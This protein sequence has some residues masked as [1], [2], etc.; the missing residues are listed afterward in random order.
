MDKESA[1][2]WPEADGINVLGIP[3]GTLEFIES[4]LFGN[5]INHRQLMGFIQE[6][7]A[8]G[9]PR[10]AVSMLTGASCPRLI[11][12][13]KSMEKNSRT[14]SWMREMDFAHLATLLHCL[15]ASP[16]LEN[17]MDPTSKDILIEWM[18][19]PPSYGEAGLNSLR[20]SADEDFLGSFTAF[21]TS[22]ISFCRKTE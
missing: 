20:R 16:N 4:Y 9:F 14:E 21:A 17:A 7:V 6:V 5:G 13:F 1:R 11:H 15:S 12:L 3:L 2:L 18:D 8:T 22:L 19:L 10:E